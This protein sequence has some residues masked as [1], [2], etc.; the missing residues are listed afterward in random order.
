MTSQQ[1]ER[2]LS[3]VIEGFYGKPWARSERLAMFDWMAAWGLNTYFYAPKDDLKQRAIWRETYTTTEADELRQL[4]E[5][6]RTRGL[7]FI[8]GLSPGLDI[9]YARQNDIWLDLA[10]MLRTLPALINQ[11][12]ET[13]KARNT[14]QIRSAAAA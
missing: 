14:P 10:I 11:V 12:I 6:C 7:Q 13:R 9:R 2:F 3:G 1:T 4:I 8:Y 5:A